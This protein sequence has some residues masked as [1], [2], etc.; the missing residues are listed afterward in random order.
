VT[1]ARALLVPV[2]LWVFGSVCLVIG[3]WEVVAPGS[4]FDNVGPFGVRNDHYIRDG[5]TFELANAI[6]L[7]VAVRRVGWRV[8][9]LAFTAARYALHTVNHF[10]DIGEADPEWVGVVDAFA[11]AAG[12]AWLMG[13]L[14][15]AASGTTHSSDQPGPV[16]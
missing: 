5:A 15:L 16:R 10:V 6:L 3:L 2:V 12:T 11:L 8:P 4:F 7:F 13:A 9:A 1:T 14:V